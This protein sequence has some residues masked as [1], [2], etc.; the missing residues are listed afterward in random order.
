LGFS[1]VAPN[2]IDAVGDRD[3]AL[4]FLF[5]ASVLAVHI[6]RL[7]EGLILFNS[8]EFGFIELDEAFATGSS[9]MPQKKNPDPLELARGKTGRMVGHLT[10]LLITL[11]GLPS[12]YDK[13]LQEDKEP[14]FDTADTLELLLPALTGLIR[15][16][17]IHPDRMS[18]LI[19]SASMATDLVDYLVQKGVPFREAH[20]AVGRA[21]RRAQEQGRSLS[22]LGLADLQELSPAFDAKASEV[23]DLEASLACR[24]VSSGTAPSALR[25]QLEAARR[26]LSQDPSA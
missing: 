25:E 14:V 1:S 2:S 4:D 24:K 19:T 9:L 18:A 15:T 7:A 3:F 13:D 8:A 10:G 26:A 22:E 11:K 17:R 16:L 6:S 23:F 20:R 12:A 21:V 5:A